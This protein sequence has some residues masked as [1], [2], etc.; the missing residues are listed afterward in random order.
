MIDLAA[1][2]Q[3]VTT[4]AVHVDASTISA[5]IAGVVIPFLVD[6]FTKSHADPHFKS[7]IASVASALAGAIPTVVYD[8][9]AG[10]K[11]YV[12]NIGLA[13]M[14]TYTTHRTGATD[15][16]QKKTASLGIGKPR[17]KPSE[18][19]DPPAGHTTKPKTTRKRTQRKT[20]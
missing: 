9:S 20:P 10:W 1:V 3:A 4:A 2:H 8:P 18:P 14:M 13:L 17:V 12:Y 6:M 5:I 19:T 15:Y 7:L 16:V 11:A